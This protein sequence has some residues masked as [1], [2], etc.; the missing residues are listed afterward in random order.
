LTLGG[1][2]PGLPAQVDVVTKRKLNE[3]NRPD[4]IARTREFFVFRSGAPAL[5]LVDFDMKGM[6]PSIADKLKRAGGLWPALMAVLPDL[7]DVARIMRRSTSAGLF[8]SDTNQP[9]TGS[10]GMHIYVA[11]QDGSDVER[12][13]KTLHAR[14]RLAGLGWMMI[15]AGG[16]LLDRS[17]VDR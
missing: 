8:R 2:R 15:G 1:L 14:C 16:Q 3:A 5:A 4:V 9:L 13:L 10:G 7:A 6:P 12:F 11:L 17:I